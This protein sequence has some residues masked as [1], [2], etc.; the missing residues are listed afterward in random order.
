MNAFTVVNYSISRDHQWSLHRAGCRDIRRDVQLHA[1]HTQQIEA[2][3]ADAAVVAMLADINEDF[4][5]EGSA[6]YGPESVNVLPC[7]RGAK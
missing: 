1:G 4:I 2:V 3:D 6:G 7:A 5:R